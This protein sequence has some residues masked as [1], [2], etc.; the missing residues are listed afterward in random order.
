MAHLFICPNC[1]NRTTAQD[2][3][4]GFRNVPKGC[5]KCGFGF[6]FELLDD[7]YPAPN[8]AFFVCDQESRIIGCGRGSRELT[9]LSDEKVIGRPVREVLGLDF[10]GGEDHVGDRA[11]VGGA[12]ARQA[13]HRE[14]RGRPAR[15]G[16]RRPLP[17][18]RRRR[19]PAARA[20]TVAVVRPLRGYPSS[21]AHVRSSPLAAHPAPGLRT[22]GRLL[23]R[24][25]DQGD[26]ARSRPPGRRPA[27]LRGAADPAAADGRPAGAG[28]RAADHARPRRRLRR[29]R[30][31]AAADR[32]PADRGQPARRGQRRPRRGAGRLHRP[33]V[34]LRLG[35]EHPRLG[36]QDQRHRG[37]RRPAAD[38]RPARRGRAGRQVH[39]RDDLR[40]QR[41]RVRAALLRVQQGLQA[42]V[43]ERAGPGLQGGRARSG[44][45]EG[46][47]QRGDPRGPQGRARHPR[48]EGPRRQGRQAAAG[49]RPL[50]GDPRPPGA[51]G[52]RH[53][54]PRAELRPAAAAATRSSPSTSRTRAA[55]RSRTSRGGSPSAAPTTRS[56][57]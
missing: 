49:S 57:A 8:A 27:R 51:L 15:E 1:G 44:R 33:A 2:R 54:E 12:P 28:P 5:Q 52:H 34:L 11:R 41:R 17:G 45:R 43:R 39:R 50:V 9:G 6:L 42:A 47:R 40:R 53:Q 31:G 38:H 16:R 23:G 36:V 24:R 26:E 25:L 29:R 30:A 56:R 3:Q 7:Y 19:R 35:S 4:Q 37:R 18:L 20:D 10:D 13:G 46:P 21:S 22:D 55:S 14:R 48:R 32:R